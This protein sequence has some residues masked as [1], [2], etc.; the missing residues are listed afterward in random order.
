MNIL[1]INHYAGSKI[2][3]MEYRPFYLAREWVALGHRVT[4]IAASASHLRTALPATRGSYTEEDLDGIQF[5]WLKTPGYHG[6]GV[7]RVLNIGA[8]VGQLWR[9]QR[10][11]LR[12]IRPDVVIAASTYVLDNVPAHRIARDCGARLVYEVRDLW[13][14]SLVELGGLS[15]HHPLIRLMQWAEDF[16]YRK[17]DRVVSALPNAE[18]H[19]RRRGLAENKF[20]Y[21]P[22]GVDPV[23]W[24]DPGTPVPPEHEKALARLKGQGRFILGY[25]GGHGVS[26][27]LTSFVDSARLLQSS[28]ISLVLVGHGPEKKTLQQRAQES[29]AD[30]IVFLPPV[31]KS[32]MRALL[33]AM[34]ACYIGWNKKPIYRYGVSPNKLFDYMMAG[35]P[36]IHAIEAPGDL[37]SESGGG[38]SIPPENPEAIAGAALRLMALS[39][40]EGEALGRKG[41]EYVLAH[42]D[43]RIL[44][45]R[46]LEAIG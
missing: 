26:N 3:G 22:N 23:E 5:V 35:K 13:P 21:V 25:T 17:A 34:D 7:H 42:H 30:N 12:D 41:R 28:P 4:V 1:L 10:R 2:H 44:A 46:Y 29:G 31:P 11:L 8:F 19:M 32:A 45:Q 33:G 18:E 20:T 39:S 27:A 9:H 40:A 36:V 38:L 6:N 43:Y 37:V 15:T 24:Q 16:V 14:L